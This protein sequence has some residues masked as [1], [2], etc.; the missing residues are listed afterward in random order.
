MHIYTYS[1]PTVAAQAHALAPPSWSSAASQPATQAGPVALYPPK[2][3]GAEDGVLAPQRL[4]SFA[5]PQAVRHCF[6]GIHAKG[7]HR[8]LRGTCPE[9]T[10][11][12]P[13]TTGQDAMQGSITDAI[14]LAPKGAKS[15][16]KWARRHHFSHPGNPR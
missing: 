7:A 15:A 3:L 10:F 11:A 8:V 4:R 5:L 6:W 2:H 13:R 9:Q 12:G 16:H 1:H 14:A